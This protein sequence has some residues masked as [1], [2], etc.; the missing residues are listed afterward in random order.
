MRS[1]LALA[2]VAQ[3]AAMDAMGEPIPLSRQPDPEPEP[4]VANQR[5]AQ[6]ASLGEFRRLSQPRRTI[7]TAE[8]AARFKAD[9]DARRAAKAAKALAIRDAQ[10]ARGQRVA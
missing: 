5:A 3:L 7:V 1:L 10:L 4:M 2:A 8:D 9:S 6:A